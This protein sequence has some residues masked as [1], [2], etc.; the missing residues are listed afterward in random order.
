MSGSLAPRHHVREYRALEA[1][2]IYRDF[3]TWERMCELVG[4]PEAFTGGADGNGSRNSERY[5]RRDEHCA[6]ACCS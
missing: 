6:P 3:D 5:T 2:D 4:W 1:G